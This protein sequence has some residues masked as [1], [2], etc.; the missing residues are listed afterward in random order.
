M[1]RAF[2]L[3]KLEATHRVAPQADLRE[4][5]EEQL[6]G[7]LARLLVGTLGVL[8]RLGEARRELE[9]GRAGP[10]ERVALR[11]VRSAGSSRG[12][13]SAG[14]RRLRH[15]ALCTGERGR[16]VVF[17]VLGHR[18]AL[19]QSAGSAMQAQ[20]AHAPS[21]LVRLRE[22]PGRAHEVLAWAVSSTR[23]A[24]DAP[25]KYFAISLFHSATSPSPSSR[26]G[27]SLPARVSSADQ[28]TD[29]LLA[30]R[31]FIRSSM[32]WMQS[33]RSVIFSSSL[34]VGQPAA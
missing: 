21:V 30:L 6:A 10:R 27:R 19:V 20:S 1:T 23:R 13:L 15:S 14:R 26:M 29:A 16:T 22:Q 2:A 17:P 7:L 3:G 28:R 12:A 5:G 25:R 33:S 34:C 18:E 31:S 4:L 11:T 8:E 24:F 32:R 9:D